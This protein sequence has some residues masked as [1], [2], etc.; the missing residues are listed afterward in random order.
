MYNNTLCYILQKNQKTRFEAEKNSNTPITMKTS[1]KTTTSAL[2]GDPDCSSSTPAR[3]TTPKT[4]TTAR[5]LE[6][7]SSLSERPR[8]KQV[9]RQPRVQNSGPETKRLLKRG[10]V[11]QPVVVVFGV[12]GLRRVDDEQSE[13][14]DPNFEFSWPFAQ[15][16]P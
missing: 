2:S 9:Q 3:P 5:N 1:S 10:E 12:V 6:R 4:T 8:R 7:S 16:W 14:P 11:V 13:L 15:P